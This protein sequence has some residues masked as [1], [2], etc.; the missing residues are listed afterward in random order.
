MWN[1]ETPGRPRKITAREDRLIGNKLKND[2]FATATAIFKRANANLGIRISK[3]A[4]SRRLN[5]INL[6]N[7]LAFTNLYF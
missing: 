1:Q 6:N 3:H 2:R 5:E 7:R 4:I